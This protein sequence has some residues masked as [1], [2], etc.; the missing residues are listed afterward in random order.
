MQVLR[1]SRGQGVRPVRPPR[2]P[3]RPPAR[4]MC[5]RDSCDLFACKGGSQFSIR[6]TN[7]LRGA[8]FHGN[9][10]RDVYKRQA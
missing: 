3:E 1:Q 6:V 8:V 5:I 4:E 10:V 7:D 9:A 2:D